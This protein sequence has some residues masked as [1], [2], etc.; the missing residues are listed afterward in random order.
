MSVPDH[1]CQ[2]PEDFEATKDILT[3]RARYLNQ[4]LKHFWERWR[5]EYLIELRESHRY[6][7]GKAEDS[8]VAIGDVVII[9]DKD[10]PRGFWRLGQ[11]QE[12]IR[13]RDGRV[14][15]AILR[16]AGKDHSS[17]LHCLLQLL[18]PLEVRTTTTPH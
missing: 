7:C 17:T 10:Q 1:L 5:N 6:N 8:Q 2:E 3:R 11:V 16:V 13:G 9:H 12:L 14:R 4:T 15:G 18:Y